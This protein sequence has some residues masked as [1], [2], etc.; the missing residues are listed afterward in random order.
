M[1]KKRL[2]VVGRN[3]AKTNNVVIYRILTSTL[4]ARYLMEGGPEHFHKWSIPGFTKEEIVEFVSDV[5]NLPYIQMGIYFGMTKQ[6][7]I[8]IQT[9]RTKTVETIGQISRNLGITHTQV[10]DTLNAISF[11]VFWRVS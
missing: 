4:I 2:K 6:L 8:D 7:P 11:R 1:L 5:E 3:W 10:R 9:C